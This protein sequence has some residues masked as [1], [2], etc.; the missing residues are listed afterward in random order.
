MHFNHIEIK[1]FKGIKQLTLEDCK[2]I[3]LI[4]GKNNTCKT[5]VLESIFLLTGMSRPEILD[6]LNNFR[7]ILYHTEKDYEQYLKFFFND[8]N[9]NNELIIKAYTQETDTKKGKSPPFRELRIKTELEKYTEKQMILPSISSEENGSCF[10]S[11]QSSDT[12]SSDDSAITKL[13][14][15]F[16]IK[17]PHDDQVLDFQSKLNLKNRTIE[18]PPEYNEELRAL[19]VGEKNLISS[20]LAKQLEFLILNKQTNEVV[21]V[22]QIIESDIKDITF[23]SNKMIYVDI[24]L[25]ILIPLNLIG[26]GEQRL[27]QLI[28]AMRSMKGGIVLIDEMENGIHFSV[29][30]KIWKVI[31]EAAKKFNVQVFITTHNIE[32]LQYLQKAVS[33]DEEFQKSI[34]NYTILKNKEGQL[35]AFKY[36]FEEFSFSIKQGIEIR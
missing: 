28:L 14:F 25:D 10:S 18:V 8:I 9:Y 34:R 33:K 4:V 22:L 7:G 2:R 15:D 23:V 17:K 36:P 13:I 32:T 16:K 21:D 3:N 19:F 20:T 30:E 26:D 31:Y 29:L 12:S 1:G 27:L 5:S 35:K 6:Q 24:G 11:K